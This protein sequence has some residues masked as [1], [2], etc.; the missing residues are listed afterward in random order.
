MSG[1]R[2]ERL[3]IT[4]GFLGKSVNELFWHQKLL[5]DTTGYWN[6]KVQDYVDSSVQ[7]SFRSKCTLSLQVILY[8]WVLWSLVLSSNNWEQETCYTLWK[9]LIKITSNLLPFTDMSQM[10]NYRTQASDPMSWIFNDMINM[11]YDLFRP[12]NLLVAN[13]GA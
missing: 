4:H 5:S 3:Q 12:I 13:K 9:N 11:G 8:I 1:Y 10:K 7:W 2:N 6:I